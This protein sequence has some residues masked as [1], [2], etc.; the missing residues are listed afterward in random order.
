M[1]IEFTVPAVPVAQPRPRATSANGYTRMYEAKGD[2]A[3]H[4]FKAAVKI[5]ANAE[6]RGTPLT[7]PLDVALTFVLPRPSEMVWKR[8]PM[9]RV[10]AF[11]KP[12]DCDNLAKGF[13]D[14]LNKLIYEDDRQVCVLSVTKMIAAGDEQPHVYAVIKDYYD[15]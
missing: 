11:A 4:T 1:R 10:P 3:I 9:P 14:A 5:A 8:K 7:G 2:H 15:F 12:Q 6:H 13:L